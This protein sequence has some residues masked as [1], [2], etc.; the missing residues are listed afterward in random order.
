MKEFDWYLFDL[1]HTLVRVDPH[2]VEASREHRLLGLSQ[3]EW[4]ERTEFDYERRAR[5]AV[6]D[7]D[8]IVA[9]IAR[10]IDPSVAGE[11]LAAVI[12][13]RKARFRRAL[14]EVDPEILGALRALRARGKPLAL[15][16]NA[17]ALDR[18][19]WDES[20]LAPLFETAVFSCDVGVMKPERAIYAIALERLGADAGRTAFVGDGGHGELSG[21]RAAGLSTVLATGII[22]GLWPG[23]IASLAR[24]ADFTVDSLRELILR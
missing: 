21:A 3:D 18:L 24:D 8:E 12:A 5:G 2:P 20:P 19:Y 6:T 1:F 7:P 16:S 9:G 11:R 17:D 15:V 14:V 23:K 13:T 4:S 22:K 10:S